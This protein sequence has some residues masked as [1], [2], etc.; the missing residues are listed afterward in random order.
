MTERRLIRPS[1]LSPDTY[2]D[3]VGLI[4]SSAHQLLNSKNTS[5][6]LKSSSLPYSGRVDSSTSVAF[7]SLPGGKIHLWKNIS[8]TLSEPLKAAT[9]CEELVYPNETLNIQDNSDSPN[10]VLEGHLIALVSRKSSGN[11]NVPPLVGL[12]ACTPNGTLCVW[13]AVLLPSK[14]RSRVKTPDDV[15]TIPLMQQDGEYVTLVSPLPPS[16]QAKSGNYGGVLIAT[17][18]DRIFLATKTTKQ[19]H[20]QIKLLNLTLKT[21][22][23]SSSVMNVLGR[24]WYGDG[25]NLNAGHESNVIFAI[26][27]LPKI[28]DH[29]VSMSRSLDKTGETSST[30]S[31]KALK[32]EPPSLFIT[33]KS[34]LVAS[35]WSFS[36]AL[37]FD[38]SK[39][40]LQGEEQVIALESLAEES[41]QHLWQQMKEINGS[42]TAG[43]DDL[44][45]TLLATDISKQP[46]Q[47]KCSLVLA[48]RAS[49]N[50]TQHRLYLLQYTLD[51]VPPSSPSVNTP[52]PSFVTFKYAH[53][54]SRYSTD[55]S[56]TL[57]CSGLLISHPNTCHSSEFVIYSMWQSLA[58]HTNMHDKLPNVT[59][60]AI[61]SAFS[62]QPPFSPRAYEMELPKDIAPAL[63]GIGTTPHI[64]GVLLMSLSGCIINTRVK[65]SSSRSSMY[66]SEVETD[67]QNTINF[68]PSEEDDT[69]LR[70]LKNHLLSYFA[71]LSSKSDASSDHFSAFVPPSLLHAHSRHLNKVVVDASL[72]IIRDDGSEKGSD[73]ESLVHG[74]LLKERLKTHTLFCNVLNHSGIYKRLTEESKS[75]LADH[76]EMISSSSALVPV[77]EKLILQLQDDQQKQLYMS[78]L[79]QLSSKSTNLVQCLQQLHNTLIPHPQKSMSQEEKTHL[80]NLSYLLFTVFS[81]TLR[82]REKYA[83]ILYDLRERGSRDCEDINFNAVPWTS[84]EQT[85]ALLQNHLKIW[86]SFMGNDDA[87]KSLKGKKEME[88]LAL[89]L[90]EGFHKK[91]SI[92]DGK[93]K[94]YHNAKAI[95]IPFLQ[96]FSNEDIALEKSVQHLYFRGI[97]EICDARERRAFR[98]KHSITASTEEEKS[99]CVDDYTLPR[100]LSKNK[101][102]LLHQT[103]DT[104]SGLTFSQFVLNWYNQKQNYG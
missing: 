21:S 60:T 38:K 76:G 75:I 80:I 45:L 69:T 62:P 30:S 12:Y 58:T 100:L 74:D 67:T 52:N 18:K 24:M 71:S 104:E 48:V 22:P 101:N 82:Y 10:N 65:V 19:I 56:A 29:D 51:L 35:L 32:K 96:Y 83:D 68:M 16:K 46:F 85:R 41:K 81:E 2:A 78:F 13:N 15:A 73:D 53:W 61:H 44:Q 27:R 6:P 93:A 20:L 59:A 90:L 63:L 7:L 8:C 49:L 1:T 66:S 25:T 57:S 34:N 28:Q 31:R 42:N 84:F 4:P 103:I 87:G 86:I 37:S 89:S 43:P 11:A 91:E 23:S 5:T 54:L 77:V 26:H 64:D 33:I 50:P 99:N 88:L 70:T 95:A 36:E 79:F 14:T 9:Q 39:A 17:N 98:L 47:H 102:N 3:V 92:L 97:V 72:Y 55:L 94:T 40:S